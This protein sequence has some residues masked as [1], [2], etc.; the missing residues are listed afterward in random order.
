MTHSKTL[1]E[2]PAQRKTEPLLLKKRKKIRKTWIMETLSKDA[3]FKPLSLLTQKPTVVY[4]R[5]F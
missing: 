4:G 2:D 5:E 3:N 1:N